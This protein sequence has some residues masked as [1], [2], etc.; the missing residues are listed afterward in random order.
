MPRAF[1]MLQ[2][3]SNISARAYFQASFPNQP[4]MWK[5]IAFI[6]RISHCFPNSQR[7]V[8]YD[9]LSIGGYT[10]VVECVGPQDLIIISFG[11]SECERNA[12]LSIGN[13]LSPTARLKQIKL[14]ERPSMDQLLCQLEMIQRNFHYIAVHEGS[15]DIMLQ[16]PAICANTGKINENQLKF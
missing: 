6:E 10:R 3:I 11:D 8:P 4:N 1:A 7:R 14:V 5:K 9:G 2:K 16:I 12:L 15:L 13:L